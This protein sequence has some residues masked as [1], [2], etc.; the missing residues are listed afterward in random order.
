MARWPA[1]NQDDLIAFYGMPKTAALESQLIDVVPPF[2]MTYAGDPVR[3][4][5]FHR[6]AA[7]AL[8]AALNEIWEAYGRDQARIDADRVSIYSGAYN[9]RYIRGSSSKWSN[10]AFGAAIDFDAEHNG[11]GT[12]HGTMPQIVI[13]AFKRQGARWG[14]NYKN[15]TD[16]MHFEFAGGGE[17]AT[18]PATVSPVMTASQVERFKREVLRWEDDSTLQGRLKVAHNADGTEIAGI[19][20]KNH[21]QI[22][23]EL[24]ALVN[25]GEHVTAIRKAGDYIM[26]YTDPV[27]TRWGARRPGVVACLRD[28]Y[29]NRGPTGGAYILQLALRSLGEN[30]GATG[31]DRDG[32]DGD[33]GP[34]TRA[35]LQRQEQL[36]S[37]RL[38]DALRAGRE[39][40]ERTGNRY[41]PSWQN[42][43]EQ[44][45][46]W[47][48]LVDRWTAMLAL[49]KQ[50][51]QETATVTDPVTPTPKPD[52][53]QP[54]AES[55]LGKLIVRMLLQLLLQRIGGTTGVTLPVLPQQPVPQPSQPSAPAEQKQEDRAADMRTGIVGAGGTL[56][57][58]LSGWLSDP[59]A[60]TVGTT[61]VTGAAGGLPSILFGLAR[62]FLSRRFT[63]PK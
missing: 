63:P 37:L 53:S 48:G 6:K 17:M 36:N 57:A 59:M 49:A 42:R 41:L 34:L 51:E 12:G 56:L 54:D 14:G 23:P 25:A 29:F 21:P 32:V 8:A 62:S 27:V 43:N 15:R 44:S 50:F 30:L 45:A 4:I 20:S 55:Q 60:A 7:P 61:I 40:W 22:V 1:D 58:W 13:D 19:T 31:V 24:L 38:L 39:E 16:P 18:S 3:A 5:K 26:S 33:V 28:S 2:R 11:M 10:H 47:G 9:P 35:A 46:A 52:T